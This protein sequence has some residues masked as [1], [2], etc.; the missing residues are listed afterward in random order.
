MSSNLIFRVLESQV[1]DY[2]LGL[3]PQFPLLDFLD[4][5]QRGDWGMASGNVRHQN[6]DAVRNGGEVV[7]R[8]QVGAFYL[9]IVSQVLAGF[10]RSRITIERM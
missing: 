6:D 7:S 2:A 1:T 5:H 4:R 9:V 10:A 8:F 3:S